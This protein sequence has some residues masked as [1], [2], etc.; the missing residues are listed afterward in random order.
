MVGFKN[1]VGNV[2][3]ETAKNLSKSP[4]IVI[5]ST[6]RSIS[7]GVQTVEESVNIIKDTL[8]KV[9]PH[10]AEGVGHAAGIG[11]SAIGLVE[12][13][14]GIAANQAIVSR[15]KRKIKQELELVK[16]STKSEQEKKRLQLEAQ[17]KINDLNRIYAS[18]KK[19]MNSLNKTSQTI[20]TCINLVNER[21]IKF[22]NN[23]PVKSVFNIPGVQ[24]KKNLI[25]MLDSY[26][27]IICTVIEIPELD[28]T[29]RMRFTGAYIRQ[30]DIVE[31]TTSFHTKRDQIVNA[32]NVIKDTYDTLS[33]PIS[34]NRSNNSSFLGGSLNKSSIKKPL[35]K[36]S[37]I[38][39]PLK[40]KSTIKKPLKKKSTPKKHIGPRGGIYIIKNG[41]KTYI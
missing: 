2:Y 23:I 36:K 1:S 38:K 30:L 16:N 19:L 28:D 31:T 4:A 6:V 13:A 33:K 24:I 21:T 5:G 17:S 39:K 25:R 26:K 41:R 27:N 12:T 14:S 40:K 35:K 7:T 32:Y 3:K 37:T 10:I 29:S 34:N 15:K 11:V 20:D 18:K 22:K 8:I 9:G